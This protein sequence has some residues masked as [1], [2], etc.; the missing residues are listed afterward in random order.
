MN[1]TCITYSTFVV[2][3]VARLSDL[4]TTFAF[5][6]KLSREWN[7]VV[8]LFG[9]NALVLLVPALAWFVLLGIGLWLYWRRGGLNLPA[10]PKTFGEFVAI[11]LRV[12]ARDRQPLSS[13]LPKKSHANQGLQAVR[14]FGVG[15]PWSITFASFAAVYAWFVLYGPLTKQRALFSML[16]IGSFTALPAFSAVI[17][18]IC[19]SYIFFRCEFSEHRKDLSNARSQSP[20]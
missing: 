3:A 4:L 15:L 6:P 1:R 9:R 7:P 16:S 8:V 10:P 5:D 17:G 14:L 11:W 12:V 19:G 2:L 18:F 20:R 13:Y